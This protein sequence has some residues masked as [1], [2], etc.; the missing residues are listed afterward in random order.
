MNGPFSL[1]I[2]AIGGEG[3][4][5]LT[6][7]I[8]AAAR[9]HG[10]AVQ[11]T[12]VPGVAQRSGATTYYIEFGEPD[13]GGRSPVFSLFPVAGQ[14]DAVLASELLEAVRAVGRGFVTPDRTTLLA[15]SHR[16]LAMT[17][18]TAAGD[19][20][21]NAEALRHTLEARS[22]RAILIDMEAL[23]RKHGAPISAVLL[24]VL[25]GAEVLAIPRDTFEQ[26]IRA[27]GRAVDRNLAAF[28]AAYE[29]VANQAGDS[30]TD[31]S[32]G[33]PCATVPVAGRLDAFPEAARA[34][35]ALG[36]DRL[37]GYQDS[38]YARLYLRRLEPFAAGDAELCREVARHLTLRMAYEDVIRVA[39]L[40]MR[41]ERFARIRDEL[42]VVGDDP[43][44]VSEYLKPGMAEICD[45]LPAFMARPLL[46]LASRHPRL[47]RF[48]VSMRLRSTTVWGYL[49]LLLLTRMRL[50]RRLTHRY[51]IEQEAIER[52]LGLVARATEHDPL[53]AR[54]VAVL[55]GLIKGYADTA[56]RSRERFERILAG[57]VEPILDGRIAPRNPA[58]SVAEAR[59]A[60]QSDP[61]GHALDRLLAPAAA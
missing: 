6:G 30:A 54:E 25:A 11:A 48:H 1:M 9:S 14:V 4:G 15:S 60:A 55:S 52:W 19:G 35:V 3:G 45:V 16:V 58:E 41:P 47:A 40:K 18:K 28:G 22:K 49:R 12:S 38:R 31:E 2:G 27:G 34:L 20:R 21:L 24:G 39:Q 51:A 43:F 32:P 10:L 37:T 44:H 26:A 56:G 50:I 46:A 33:H 7:W 5:V 8:V 42:G 13:A 17:E 29:H 36:V 53:L 61:E 23:A 59:R 57:L